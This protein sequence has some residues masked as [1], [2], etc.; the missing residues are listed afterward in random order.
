MAQDTT[1]LVEHLEKQNELL[2]KI[3]DLQLRQV[4]HQKRH[5]M[6]EILLKVLPFVIVLVLLVWLY[7]QMTTA[8]NELTTQVT[9]IRVN[10]ESV[11]GLLTNQFATI[12]EY[13]SALFSNIKLL[14]PNFGDVPDLIQEQFLSS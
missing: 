6:T 11:F 7:W 3:Y 13:F 12:N 2:Q 14:I 4:Q 9:D 5:E 8:L 1:T 10:V